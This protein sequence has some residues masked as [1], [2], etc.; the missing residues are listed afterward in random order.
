MRFGSE[1][2]LTNA[3]FSLLMSYILTTSTDITSEDKLSKNADTQDTLETES[4]V[5]GS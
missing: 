5:D 1:G 3:I 2:I 4:A